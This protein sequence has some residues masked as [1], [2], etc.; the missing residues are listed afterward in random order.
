MLPIAALVWVGLHLGV[1]GSRLR[2]AIVRSIGEARFRAVFSVLSL[3]VL[4]ILILEYRLSGTTQ[5]WIAPAWLKAL[6]AVVMLP[7]FALFVGAVSAPNPTAIGGER[8]SAGPITGVLR[9]TRYPMLW[10]FA[11]WGAV[12]LLGNGDTA[13][14][15]FFGAFLVT[16]LA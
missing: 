14:I 16:A 5:L 4:A 13:A 8:A 6:F 15:A 7:A 12:H 11:I 3:A 1:A 9:V 2:G 10:S